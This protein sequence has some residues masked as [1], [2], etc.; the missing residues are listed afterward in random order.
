MNDYPDIHEQAAAVAVYSGIAGVYALVSRRGAVMERWEYE[1]VSYPIRDVYD[2]AEKLSHVITC[3]P[4]GVCLYKDMP[5]ASRNEIMRIL[6]E[7]GE[8]GWELVETHYVDST[9]DLVCIFKKKKA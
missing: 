4:A 2:A 3:D 8:K 6:N 1:I 9:I 7:Q 5:T